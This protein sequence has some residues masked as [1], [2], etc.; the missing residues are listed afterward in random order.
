MTTA[1]VARAADVGF[2]PRRLR[3][4]ATEL[5]R[6]GSNSRREPGHCA[7]TLLCPHHVSSMGDRSSLDHG[8]DRATR[9]V[10]YKFP[11]HLD[12]CQDSVTATTESPTSK[13]EAAVAVLSAWRPTKSRVLSLVLNTV[14]SVVVL[15]VVL[16]TSP[17]IT[18]S[19]DASVLAAVVFTAVVATLLRPV[20]VAVAALMRPIAALLVGLFPQ[21]VVVYVAIALAPGVSVSSFWWALFAGW[22]GAVLSTLLAWVGDADES[23]ALL[24]VTMRQAAKSGERIPPNENPGV[25]FVQI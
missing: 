8:P 25:L 22:Y 19:N 1:S 23:D 16:L 4:W 15:I 17:G 10:A 12:V 9:R 2:G 13:P 14:M 18:V 6:T 21:A 7:V 3:R 24:A 20:L 11:Q 5:V